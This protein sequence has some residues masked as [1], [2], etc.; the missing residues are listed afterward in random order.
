MTPTPDHYLFLP[1]LLPLL[2]G[3]SLLLLDSREQKRGLQRILSLLSTAL[4]LPLSLGLLL[5]VSEGEIFL[6]AL[7]NW[8]PPFGIVLVFDRLAVLMLLLTA[9]VGL[10]S[11]VYAVASSTDTRGRYFHVLFQ[12][13]LFGLNGAFVT[14]DLFNL[15]V[16]FEILLIASYGL[17]LHGGGRE[18]ARAGLH[19]VVL[20]LT[21]SALFLIA[22]GVLYGITGT[23]NMADLATRIAQAEGS[24]A[25]LLRAGALLLLVV[26]ALK[27]ALLPL[28]FWLPQ[29]YSLTS[30]AIA[31][32]F[33]I[34][35]KVGVYAIVRVFTLIFGAQAGVAANVAAPWLLPLALATLALGAVGCLAARDLRRLLAYLV[36]ISVGTLLTAVGLFSG[37]GL[38]AAIVYLMHSTLIGAAMFL[39]ADLIE[40]QRGTLDLSSPTLAVAQPLLLGSMFVIGAVALVGLPPL[41]GFIAKLLIMRAADSGL[42]W[43]W[44]LLLLSGLF[45]LIAFSRSGSALFWHTA[46]TRRTD[47]RRASSGLALGLV[48]PAFVLLAASPMLVA[49]AAPL[50]DFAQATAAQLL[51]PANYITAVLGTAQPSQ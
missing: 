26:F 4:L 17:L 2:S 29:A 15:F 51:D 47:A 18:L 45:S 10:G 38:S 42:V 11:L 24:E 50:N 12:F 36:V 5:A 34:M 16:C 1:V 22:I 40:R 21:G 19:Y 32:L 30:S 6:Y 20:N 44:G 3:A 49:L 35:T 25:G 9:L 7:G 27:A 46:P 13:Q 23:L 43:I 48:L 14:G 39:V 28:Y 33:A 8:P 31:A 37:P 41:S